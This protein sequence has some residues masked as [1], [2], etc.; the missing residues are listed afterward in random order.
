[1]GVKCPKC[2]TENPDTQKFCGECATPLNGEV[3]A[4]YTKT[5]E[6]PA[7]SMVQGIL[8]A[9]RY[10]VIEKLGEG[11]MGKV[12][13]VFDKKLEEE[14]ALKLL[15]PEIA[16][17]EKTIERF[18]NELKL[19]RRIAHRNVCKMYDL[20]EEKEIHFI[21][22]EYVAGEDLKS[23]VR[24]EKK[25]SQE[26]TVRIA[27]QICEGL[28]E[29]HKLGVVHRDLK[30]SNIMI[31]KA[32]NARIMDFGIAR[33]LKAKGITVTGMMI[34][35]PEYMSPE[36]VEGKEV[37]QKS[38]IYS[39][40]VILY[41]MLTGH[42]PFKGETSLSIAYKHKHEQPRD[43]RKIDDQITEAM[44]SLVLRCLEKDKE[45]RYQNAGEVLCEL[46]SG[47]PQRR[48]PE[49]IATFLFADIED[50]EE[51]VKQLGEEYTKLLADHRTI[52][53]EAFEESK[54]REIDVQGDGVFY[55]FPKTADAVSAAVLGQRVVEAHIWPKG[56]DVRVCMGL[57]AGKPLDVCV[58]GFAGASFHR[59]ARIANLGHGGQVLLSE[60]T[61]RLIKEEMPEGVGLRDLGNHRLKDLRHPE[62]I[63]QLVIPGLPVDFPSLKSLDVHPNNLPIQPTSLVGRDADLASSRNLLSQTD[64]HLL[65][66][67]GPGGTGKTRLGLQLAAELSDEFT[68][69]VFFVPLA[70]IADP[71]L[72]IPT[73]A[74]TLGL[75][76]RGSQPILEVLEEF[77]RPKKM[78]LLLDS[79]EHVCGAAVEVAHLLETCPLIKFLVTSRERLH[80]R[81]EFEFLVRPLA[82]PDVSQR[83][84]VDALTRNPAV[85]LFLQRAQSVK[86]EFCIS[87]ENAK[88]VAEIC[89]RLDGL[90]LA[91]ELAAARIR[92]FPPEM[93]LK[94]LIKADGHSSLHLLTH[95]PRDAPQ[96]HQTLHAA[97]D[98][99]YQL[100]GEEEQKLFQ[101]LSVFAGGFT[102]QAVEAVCCHPESNRN[103]HP[104]E[105]LSMDI[106]EALA[107]L[108]D[109]NLL[110]QY[111]MSEDESR[112]TMLTLIREYAGEK[113]RESGLEA[114]ARKRHADFF[115]SLAVEAEPLL[116][117]LEQK[118]WLD[119][120]EEEHN[121]LRSAL[122]WFVNQAEDD[123]ESSTAAAESGLRMAG[124][125]WRFWDTHGH[126]SEGR[127]WL[128]KL[129]ALSDT[130]TIERVDALAGAAW[131]AV[132]QSDMTEA[133]QLYKQ[134]L[135]IA[136][137]ISYKAGIAKALGGMGDVKE[138]LGTDDESAKALYSESLE[139]W[140]D[141]GDKW[142]IATALG[143]LAHRAASAYDFQQANKLFEESL[144]LF[145]EVQDKREIAGALWNLGQIAVVLGHLD[146]AREMY[147][148]S[149]KI[150]KDLKDHHG[151]ATQLRSLGKVERFQGNKAQAH[152]LYEESL[153]S[154]RTMGD[155]G[156]AS[157][158][159]V[160]LGRV[161]L[162]QGYI[163]EAKSLGRECLNISREIRFK[164]VEAQALRLLGQCCLAEGDPSSARKHF[165][166]SM[167]LEQEVDHREGIG[168]N[169]EGIACV[170][171]AQFEFEQAARLFSAAEAL[172]AGL[173]LPLPPVDAAE[174]EKWKAAVR[175]GTDEA[176]YKSAQKE[177]SVLTMEQAIELAKGKVPNPG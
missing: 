126:V 49:G 56:V 113:L 130:P 96:R 24:R 149:L 147:R 7:A 175:D 145:R 136:R 117:G 138:L 118:L 98:W 159:I 43:P 155:R 50:S 3:Q 35:T 141:V 11:G 163:T 38:D 128:K 154:F 146:K 17:D 8:F 57:H 134:A 127:R 79:F 143:P 54:G 29:A 81:G 92:L 114:Q 144:A 177:G 148:E 116:K 157:I 108:L 106:M 80:V 71:S 34:G 131:L 137:G 162:D 123:K 103:L 170:T 173:G 65:T 53:R 89:A 62:R 47:T 140:R 13:R 6:T 172:R 55:A 20:N 46:I 22:M 150:Y 93:L 139:M 129:F 169:L 69:G 111:E 75:H 15:N 2:K 168:E 21:T 90:P 158:A 101:I 104:E 122:G 39:L 84:S 166:E 76:D 142:G 12:Y 59:A 86:P 107:S 83:S 33:S 70:P 51:L 164:R 45:K 44:S 61:A 160:G 74:Q 153:K 66:L 132:R 87:E 174:L 110:R 161:A 60:A 72:V 9:R 48:F 121:N 99:S 97:M 27:Q 40:G 42:V 85:E 94:R 67:T 58:E 23:R 16:S 63:F 30:P 31:D 78:L 26:E 115:L 28:S 52:L 124:A 64:V 25:I 14:I 32:G 10:E 125:L 95:G 1:M 135:E 133:L 82:F 37:D 41:E 112:F 171:A 165:I 91:I 167:H 120:L 119:R 102:L 73:V 77:L 100:L 88:P 18:K 5:L 19:A 156:C 151:I 176:A 105:A 36:Q 4:S 109:K 68:D 152:A